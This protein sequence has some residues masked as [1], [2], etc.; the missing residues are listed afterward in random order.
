MIAD[1]TV[2]TMGDMIGV[3][4]YVVQISQK[5]TLISVI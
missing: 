1:F 4:E 3:Q 2:G 5:H